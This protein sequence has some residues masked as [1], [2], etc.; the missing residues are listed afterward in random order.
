MEEKEVKKITK[1]YLEK[2]GYK[3]T[4]EP[5]VSEEVRLDLYAF[6]YTEKRQGTIDNETKARPNAIWIECKGDVGFSMVL[7]GLIRTAFAIHVNGG[8]G[9][10]TLPKKQYSIMKKYRSFLKCEEKLKVMC[11]ENKIENKIESFRM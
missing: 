5:K 11:I 2:Q 6:K 8:K 10:L 9:M 3:V 7:E 1:K 4:E